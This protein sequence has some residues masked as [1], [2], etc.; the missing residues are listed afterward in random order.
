MTCETLVAMR[1][2]CAT[3][4]M[5]TRNTVVYVI[6]DDASVRGAI[7]NLLESVSLAAE[8]YGS[9]QEFLSAFRPDL[10]G[11]LI[12]DIR[13]PD[14]SGLDF[15]TSLISRGVHIPIIFITGHG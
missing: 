15:Q 14:G 9:P 10:P 8:T 1:S 3:V 11:C 6:D 12:L 4:T 7:R 2:G 5:N 13:L